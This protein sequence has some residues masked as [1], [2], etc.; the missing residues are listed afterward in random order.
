MAFSDKGFTGE[1]IYMLKKDFLWNH[2]IPC[3]IHLHIKK[4][5]RKKA[6]IP[7]MEVVNKNLRFKM[8]ASNFVY[9]LS[10]LLFRVPQ[11]CNITVQ[12]L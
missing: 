1:F 11:C 7:G 4:K 9:I 10:N 5:K 3:D 12:V 2:E 6:K 8:I